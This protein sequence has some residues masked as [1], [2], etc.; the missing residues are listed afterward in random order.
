MDAFGQAALDF[1][2]GIS[3][4]FIYVESETMEDDVIPVKHLFR[5]YSEMPK[6]E[7]VALDNAKGEIL[8]VGGGAGSHC[9]Y[10]EKKGMNTTLLDYSAGLCEV[11]AKLGIKSIVHHDFFS[12]KSKKKYDS[13]LFMMNGIGIGGNIK[14]F[15]KTIKKSFELLNNGGQ[16]LFDSTDISFC[17]EEEDGSIL[18]PLN[19]EYHGFVKFQLKYKNK[20]DDWFNWAYYDPIKLREILPVEYNFEILYKEGYAYC[21]KITLKNSTKKAS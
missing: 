7:Q 15:Q 1:L 12:W 21:G 3:D 16:I 17:Y 18:L 9:L 2:K 11:S 6:C 19:I 8:D 14:S 5:D 4:E 13:I 20:K 10:L